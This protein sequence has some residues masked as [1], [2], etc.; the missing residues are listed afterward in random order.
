MHTIM[1]RDD[2]LRIVECA[3]EDYVELVQT[4]VDDAAAV[5]ERGAQER[6]AVAQSIHARIVQAATG[7]DDDG[8]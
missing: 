6:L 3:M 1:L 4:V 7:G 5:E 8:R 2:E